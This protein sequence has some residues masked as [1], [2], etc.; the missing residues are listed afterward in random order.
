MDLATDPHILSI[1]EALMDIVVPADSPIAA[2]EIPGGSPANV[3]MT[4]GRLG[5][6]VGLQTMNAATASKNTL[7]PRTLSSLRSPSA[8]I[9]HRPHSQ[10][11][12][13][14][15]RQPTPLIPIGVQIAPSPYPRR[16]ESFTRVPLLR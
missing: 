16:L 7:R 6:N 3:A 12:T 13:K 14:R 1:G 2:V 10:S 5:R 4:L 11:S 8:L 9:T 15:A